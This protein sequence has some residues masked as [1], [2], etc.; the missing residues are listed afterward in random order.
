MHNSSRENPLPVY[1]KEIGEQG[2]LEETVDV[3]GISNPISESENNQMIRPP[4]SI[5]EYEETVETI[6]LSNPISESENNQMIRPQDS[7]TEYEET[8]ETIDLSNSISESE[9]KKMIR[10]P[11]S[12]TEYEETVGLSE[13]SASESTNMYNFTIYSDIPVKDPSHFPEK[14]EMKIIPVLLKE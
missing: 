4:D 1:I 12:I 8:V 5:T 6:D 10:P 11:E 9:N 3:I 7:I 14:S 2:N 13:E